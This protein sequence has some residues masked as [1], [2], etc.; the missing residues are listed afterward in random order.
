MDTQLEGGDG[1]HAS[2]KILC[3]SKTWPSLCG[4][5]AA[6]LGWACG[7][8]HNKEKSRNGQSA[9]SGSWAEAERLA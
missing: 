1:R 8:Q 2:P 3:I 7:E 6:F 9:E 5:T 4:D